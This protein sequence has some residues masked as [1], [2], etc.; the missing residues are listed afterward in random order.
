MP[1]QVKDPTLLIKTVNFIVGDLVE[2]ACS[3]L[4]NSMG[5]S[6]LR[7]IEIF[8]PLNHAIP[9]KFYRIPLRRARGQKQDKHHVL[10]PQPLLKHGVVLPRVI[11]SIIQY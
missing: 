5:A 11:C 4:D 10:G 6:E 3:C 2:D 1:V 8:K 7:N 9:H